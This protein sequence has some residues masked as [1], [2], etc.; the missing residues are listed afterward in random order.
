[1]YIDYEKIG[2]ILG[3]GGKFFYEMKIA[4]NCAYI[5]KNIKKVKSRLKGKTQLNVAF[6]V[7]DDSKWK[8]QSLYDLMEKD[9]R[10]TPYIF[11]TKSA[12]PKENFNYQDRNDVEKVYKFFK[13][14]NMRIKYAYNIEKQKFIPFEEMSPKPDIIIYQHPWY[15]ETS[16]GPVVCSKFALTYYVPYFISDTD[17]FMEYDLRFHRYIY[18]YY[19]PDEII[20]KNYA[21]N[22]YDKGK[23]LVV[24]GHPQ[25]DYYLTDKT[26]HE[27]KYVIYTPHWTVCGNNL[28][29]STFDWNGW[30]I[31][32][33]AEQHKELNWVFKPH[34]CLYKFLFMSGYMSKEEADKYYKRWGE[35]AIVCENGNYMELFQQS[36]AM[37]TDSGSF[38]IEYFFTKQPCIHLVSEH[39]AGNQNARDICSTYYNV[40]NLEEMYRIFEEILINKQD[41][42]KQDRLNLLKKMDYP[43]SAEIIINDLG[44]NL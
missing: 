29:Y 12:A 2:K 40:Y 30:Q 21:P 24:A 9:E 27:R 14:R 22:M 8:C 7:Y 34:P 13:T 25:L 32:E 36:R 33:F 42:K 6:Y 17:N 44:K 41:T 23:K 31:L 3:F 20:R 16:Q 28:R 11:V 19:V 35:F 4:S 18:R 39:F 10:F 1:M 15:V 38:L 26:E 37:I 43:Y 5:K